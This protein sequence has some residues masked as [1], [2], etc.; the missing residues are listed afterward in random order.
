MAGRARR[1]NGV[2]QIVFDVAAFQA[3]L[4]RQRRHRPRLI[5]QELNEVFSKRDYFPALSWST[6]QLTR[7]GES[8]C[9]SPPTTM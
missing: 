6:Y 9:D 8:P 7:V 4:T 3:E 1:A 2:A 5:G